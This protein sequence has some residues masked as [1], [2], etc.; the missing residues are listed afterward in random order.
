MMN[1]YIP[2]S[3]RLGTW[4]KTKKP[5]V[6]EYSP[7]S[8]TMFS[9]K[10]TW[11]SFCLMFFV[12]EFAF[13]QTTVTIGSGENTARYPLSAYYGF[14]RSTAIYTAN[15]VNGNGAI[16]HLAWY[17]NTASTTARPIVIYLKTTGSTTL[18]S[19]TGT[20]ATL[21]D[22]ATQVYSGSRTV[23]TGWNTITLDTSFIYDGVDNLQVFVETNYGGFGTDS[24]SG[25]ANR[26]STVTNTHG[27][28]ETDTNPPTANGTRN[29]NRPN[30]QITLVSMEDCSG[31]PNAGTASVSPAT[32]NPGSGYTVSASGITGGEGIEYQ[33]QSN[34]NNGGWVDVS[35]ATSS[36]YSA[37]APANAG[38]SVQW[39]LVTTCTNSSESNTSA[40][41][42]FTAVLTYCT[43]TY[44]SGCSFGGRINNVSTTG[45]S[46]N[47]TN[48]GTGCSAGSYM[49]YSDTHTATAVQSSV[50]NFNVE[51][52]NYASGV[53]IWVDWNQNGTFDANELMASSS[54]SIGAGSS[55]TGSFTVPAEALPGTTKMRVRAV[56]DSTTFDACSSYSWGEAEDYGF[57]VEAMAACSGT[58]NAGTASVNPGTGNP[59]STYTVS[60]SGITAGLGIEYQWQ[61]N[62]NNGGWVDVPGATSVSYEATAPANIGDSVQWRLVTTCTNSSESNTSAT[63]TFTAVLTYCTPTY[64]S[65]CSF[66][67]RINNVSTTGA[68]TNI[69]NNGTGCSA[70][71]Y[72]DYSDTHT[73]T[74]VQSS[75]VNFNV[76]I[77]NYAS[78]VKIWVDWNQN[79]TFDANELMASSSSSI[80]A[81]SSY[82][83]SFTVPAEALPGTTKMRVRAVED[84]TTFDACSSYSWGEAEDY[85]FTVEAMAACSGTPNAGTASVNPGTGNP[86][87]T[88]TVSA[89]GITAGLGIEYQWQSNTNNGGWVDVPGATSVSYEATAP[90]NI[91][92]SVQWRLVT[93]CTNSSESNTS[94][95]ATFTTVHNYCAAEAIDPSYESISNVTFADINN[96]SSAAVGY[97]NFTSVTGTVV[98]GLTYPFSASFTGTSYVDDQVLVWIDFNQNGDFND[99]GELVLTTATGASPWAGNIFIPTDA[100]PGLTRM[101]VRLHDSTVNPNLTPCGNSGYGQ[102]EDYTISIQ[103]LTDCSG[104]PDGGTA[105]VS[106]SEDEAGSTYTVSASGYGY[107]IGVTYQW[108]SNT[109]DGGWVNAGSSSNNY[110]DYTATAPAFGSVVQ[111]R[112][113]TTCTNSSESNTSSEAVFTSG[114]CASVPLDSDFDEGITN[115][116]FTGE[117]SGIN[118]TSS[119]LTQYSDYTSQSADVIQGASY[120]LS[121]SVNTAISLGS[122]TFYQIAWID[123]NQNGVFEA[124]ERYVLGSATNGNN[125][126]SSESPLTITVPT[127]AILG[128]TRMRIQTMYQSAYLE[129]P[130]LSQEGDIVNYDGETEDYTIIV[131][132]APYIASLNPSEVCGF[133]ETVTVSGSN[134]IGITD[135]SVGSLSAAFEV[136][137]ENTITFVVPEGTITG[138][139]VS[140]TNIE[141]TGISTQTLTIKPFPTVNPITGVDTFCFS[142]D[143]NSFALEVAGAIGNDWSSSDENI[144]TVN[145]DGLV[146]VHSAGEVTISFS[147]TD[148]GCTTTV[149]HDVVI[150]EETAIVS[151]TLSQTVVTGNIATF[152]VNATGTISGYQWYYNGGAGDVAI[153]DGPGAYGE[154]FSGSNTATLTISNTPEDMSWFEFF[155]VISNSGLCDDVY[156]ENAILLVG[157]TGIETDPASVALCSTVSN[158]AQFT[159]VAIG[160]VDSYYWELDQTED[161][162]WEEISDG[163]SFGLTF[164]GSDTDVLYVTGI[165][166]VHNGWRF[167]VV[168]NGPANSAESNVA[169]LSFAEGISISSQPQSASICLD[170][171]GT[172]NFSVVAS[173]GIAGYTWQ[174]SADGV[175][176]ANVANNIPAGVTYGGQDS[177]VLSVTRSASTPVGNHY[178]R[179]VIGADAPCGSATSETAIMNVSSPNIAITASADAY[180]SPGAEAVVLTAS[181]GVSY[182]WSPADGLSSTTGSVVSATPSVTT[183]YTVTGTDANGCISTATVTVGVGNAV[184]ATASSDLDTVCPEID[185][186]LSSIGVQ[187]FVTGAVNTYNFSTSTGV[188]LDPMTGATQLL[189]SSLDDN[190]S[191]VTNIGFTFNYGGNSYTQFSV[192]ANGLMRLGATAVT[193]QWANTATNAATNS[194]AI[195]P[196]WDDLATGTGGS[197]RYK[198]SGTAPNR[199]LI[200]EWFVTVPRNTLGAANARFQAWL[201][202]S[203]SAVQ[204]VYGS[205]M[206]TNTGGY[207]IGL[208]T[209]ATVYN[210]AL[211]TTNT[212]STSIFYT[213]ISAPITAGRTYMFTPSNVPSYTYSWTSEPAGFTST[214][215]NPVVNPSATTTYTVVVT[216]TAS[217][218][219]DAA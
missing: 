82:T 186:Q 77:Q 19:P 118:N 102:V 8:A 48:N 165:T 57:T 148:N 182:T 134:F 53:K 32:G 83:G 2:L 184:T 71:S 181:G 26:Y 76:E 86:G 95:A 157:D 201:H 171:A 104:T 149:S 211:A 194:P 166:T 203:N 206:V 90:A 178:Y 15:E 170:P 153:S 112:L 45:A 99:P 24:S 132:P 162:W 14:S 5:D 161:G 44:S 154:T 188:A 43:P 216:D 130:C 80:G 163:S 10:L 159:V 141:G 25:V 119:G 213:T 36:N 123:W 41:A 29:N 202:E 156:S 214:E 31:Q 23:T 39:R 100:L 189:G 195:M 73:A 75:V 21:T 101:R 3:T 122:L 187:S 219:N 6:G 129:H 174:Y 172:Q 98:Q 96:N 109:N 59:G 107:G 142:S 193:N 51:I 176:F 110:S 103:A 16:T 49:D 20:W 125:I 127:N 191:A 147:V 40:T 135:V 111:W 199:I 65:G 168:V 84:S 56:E 74:A 209:S 197:V 28:W 105:F 131:V 218:C 128:Q 144:A 12:G 177:S 113:I 150:S 145:G 137:D 11:L 52:Q 175:S 68:S 180:C 1:D 158:E 139:S 92:D 91:G 133:G 64:S 138:S 67:G 126:L 70:G 190:A 60:A 17:A 114:Y 205:G 54:S 210:N 4:L 155:V 88:Y 78:G 81:G 140:V 108:Q 121:V 22:G 50:V 115:V 212:G 167:R 33:W 183:V 72:M 35:G 62:T 18:A 136:I 93:T 34:T 58:P 116:T 117:T 198:V 27:Y 66:G 215:K 179:V 30:I 204:F 42:T 151:Q 208:A 87:S 55:Y 38:D 217:G 192:N 7:R 169:I 63:A 124:G 106:V 79:G 46:T 200:V 207:T 143:A 37:T 89:S 160:E 61:S 173:G 13:S 196:Y 94:S 164:S 9:W 85:G 69:T 120:Q 152:S 146:T 185:V 97:E 47:I